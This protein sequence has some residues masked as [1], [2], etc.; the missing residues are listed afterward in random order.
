MSHRYLAGGG[1]LAVA[2]ALLL[3]S[4]SLV[5]QAPTAKAGP[6]PTTPWGAADLQGIWVHLY[7]TPLQRPPQYADQEVFT[8][9]ERAFLDKRRAA[10]LGRDQRGKKG[11]EEDVAGAYNALFSMR[12]PTGRRTSLIVD[13]PDGRVPP[14][15]PGVQRRRA[16][17]RAFQ[18][19]LLQNTETC[20]NDLPECRG[21]TYGPPSPKR[22]GVFPYY[23]MTSLMSP[24]M[25]RHDNPE[26]S[27][28]GERCMSGTLP[29]LT[30]IRRIVQSPESVSIY[31]E[32]GPIQR[33]IPITT[34]PHHSPK[35][36]RW[37]GDSRGHWEGRTL[38]VD[39]TNFTSK[40]DF[41]GSRENLHL[42]ERWTRLDANTLE[43]A[44]TLEDPT[45]WARPW[46]VK[47][48]LTRQD[49]QANRIYYEPRCIEGNYGL[50]GQLTGSRAD[51]K[52]F[53]E[54][55]GPHP[56]TRDSSGRGVG[57]DD[58]QDP[59]TCSPGG[60]RCDAGDPDTF[61]KAAASK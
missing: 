9:E 4:T 1:A 23:N 17:I 61:K 35:V 27:T 55:R 34:R 37:W 31:S 25:N 42:V 38:V 18:L 36:R 30:G 11:T 24:Y 57:T 2:V 54:G 20:K 13:P 26:D 8:D 19:A 32:R 22:D 43:Y 52:V 10:L 15:M 14:A 6:A 60:S 16:E 48:E 21:G 50:P 12:R 29:S 53:A 40:T 47:V 45:T 58:N 41:W 44:V 49:N 3:A 7:Q 51:E 39:V 28:M 5:G 33:I 56:A 59:L 46:T